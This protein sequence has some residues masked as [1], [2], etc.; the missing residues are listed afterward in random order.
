MVLGRKK[1]RILLTW[2]F[3][4]LFAQLLLYAMLFSESESVLRKRLSE[5]LKLQHLYRSPVEGKPRKLGIIFKS[6]SNLE[7]Q[8]RD[9]LTLQTGNR[10]K[11]VS[12]KLEKLEVDAELVPNVRTS[13]VKPQDDRKILVSKAPQTD[14]MNKVMFV[15][16]SKQR[17]TEPEDIFISV[18]TTKKYH[19]TRV[20]EIR[21]TWWTTAKQQVN[22]YVI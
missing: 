14:A 11:I 8:I 9:D 18:K 3:L 5:R 12:R 17:P 13:E 22:I 6:D 7:F 15:Q 20:Q 10:Q 16:K 4:V 2:I 19:G 21:N 1:C